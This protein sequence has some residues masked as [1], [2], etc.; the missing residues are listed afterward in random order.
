MIISEAIIDDYEGLLEL[1]AELDEF[2]RSNHPELFIRPEKAYRAIEYIDDL[3]NSNDKML[4]IAEE[5]SKI[6]GLAECFIANSAVFPIIKKRKWVQLDSIAVRQGYQ[7]QNV[8]SLLLNEVVQWA[9]SKKI[10]RIELKTYAFNQNAA[11]FYSKNG[12][13][14][15]AKIMY[16]DLEK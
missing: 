12:F 4:V 15:L 10:N 11:R 14:G 9:K 13:G 2:H 1:Y 6:I 8:G 5:G 16:L 7:H 3:I